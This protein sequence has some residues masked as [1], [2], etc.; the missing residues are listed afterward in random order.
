MTR[1]GTRDGA[2][3]TALLLS[4][5][6]AACAAG[7][8]AQPPGTPPAGWTVTAGGTAVAGQPEPRDAVLRRAVA[9]AAT[10]AGVPP[11]QV[12]VLG[13]ASREWS[14]GSLGCP[15]PGRMY[16][17]AIV[18]GYLVELEAAGQRLE[19]HADGIPRVIVLCQGGRPQSVP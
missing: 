10:R 19:Y 2:A 11:G 12:R 4:L 3:V 8:P 5:L 13:V 15:E 14:D 18:S 1:Q 7:T 17:Q 16:T 6:L 9:D